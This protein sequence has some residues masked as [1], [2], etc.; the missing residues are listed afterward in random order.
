MNLR[1]LLAFKQFAFWTAIFG[2]LLL[3]AIGVNASRFSQACLADTRR[4]WLSRVRAG[5][6]W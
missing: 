6:F 4:R 5:R 3:E 1:C 2:D